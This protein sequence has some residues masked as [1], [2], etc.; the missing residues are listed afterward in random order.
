LGK[1][2]GSATSPSVTDDKGPIG[3]N[4]ALLQCVR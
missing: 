4:Q 3:E 1:S 2:R